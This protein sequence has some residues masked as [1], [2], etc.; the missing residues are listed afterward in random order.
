MATKKQRSYSRPAIK[1]QLVVNSEIAIKAIETY[2]N[3]TLSSI[4]ALDVILFYI[5]DDATS[6]AA[7]QKI[8]ALFDEKIKTFN[9]KISK[10][11]AQVE[12][13]GLGDIV[14]TQEFSEE[15][16]VFSPLCGQYIQLI[17]KFDNI[18]NL[19]DQLWL[20]GEISSKKRKNEVVALKRHLLNVSRRVINASRTAMALAKS[21]GKES[22]VENAVAG[23]GVDSETAKS[24]IDSKKAVQEEVLDEAEKLEEQELLTESA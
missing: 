21:Q 9:G 23:L 7:N 4:Y 3:Q 11:Q 22:E 17:K 8:A 2:M 19:I 20:N 1:K 5:S 14:Y 13:L 18:T 12:E 15:Y 16:L 6:E 10:L 24:V